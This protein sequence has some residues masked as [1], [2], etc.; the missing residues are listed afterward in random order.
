MNPQL[1]ESDAHR[2]IEEMYHA[3]ARLP[4]GERLAFLEPACAGDDAL[5]REVQSLLAA[6]DRAADFMENVRPSR[7]PRRDMAVRHRP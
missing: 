3:A 1:A 6:H 5:L 7:P 4:S 2:R